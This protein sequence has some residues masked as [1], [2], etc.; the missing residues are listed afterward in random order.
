[1]RPLA[2]DLRYAARSLAKAPLFSAVAIVSL[3]LALA[4]NTSVF[5]LADA[6]VH[7]YNPYPTAERIVTPWFMGGDRKNKLTF[8]E[9]FRIVRDEMHSYDAI[10]SFTDLRATMQAGA[11]VEDHLAVA[12]SSNLFELLGVKPVLGRAFDPGDT[13]AAL[14]SFSLWTRVFNA[15]PLSRGLRFDLGHATFTAVGVMPRGVHFPGNTDIW[16]PENA[17]SRASDERAMGP[18]PVLRLQR[19]KTVQDARTEITGIAARVTAA[20]SPRLPVG[21]RIM[22]LQPP[23]GRPPS[24]FQSF[25]GGT[26]LMVLL[27]ACANLATMMLARGMARR[28]ETA[29]RMALGASRR[30]VVRQVLAECG[31]IVGAGL[32]IGVLLTIWALH[33]IP[34]FAT[35]YVPN[36]GDLQPVP[37]W[38][39]FGFA[40]GATIAT[41]VIAG[42]LPALRAASTDPSEPMKEGAGTTTGRLRDRYNPL[43]IVEVALSTALLM[44]SG[45]FVINVVRLA[46]F[47]FQYAAKRLVTAPLFANPKQTPDTLGVERFYDELVVRA[48]RVPRAVIAATLH[49]E[50]PDGRVI[51][52][53]EG[54]SGDHWINSGGV[55]VVSPDYLRTFRIPIVTGRDFQQGD[56]GASEQG[57]VIV[58]ESAAARL[59]PDMPDPVGRMVKL[60][61]KESKRP[62]LRVVGVAHNVEDGPRV[63]QDLPPEPKV[64][65]VYAHDYT[66]TR[67]L[68][69]QGDGVDGDRGRTALALAVRR[70]IESFAPGMSVPRVEPWLAHYEGTLTATGY[71]ASLFG[72]FGIFGLVLCAVGLYGVLAYS[73]SRRLREFAVRVA[74]GARRRDVARI[75][76]HDAAVTA[77]A[78]VGIGAFFALRVTRMI[79]DAMSGMPYATVIALVGA[80]LVLFGAAALA[81][82]GPIRRAARADPVEI[83]RAI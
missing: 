53:E 29:I 26:V 21:G 66:R 44:C 51:F 15:A 30:V 47:E 14:I 82:L 59:W 23:W 42:A 81:A 20:Y 31:L 50:V 43:I 54:K 7:P 76:I 3:G 56:E 61:F 24:I 40:L 46:A 5:A 28:R 13:Q 72:A 49:G 38:R 80:E 19:G 70:E 34:H 68:I 39:V 55:L 12:A 73:V 17:L 60:G 10:A 32:A 79:A 77:L 83:L 48:R 36:I 64:Y 71:M 65:V 11:V 45:F 41:I 9:R 6:V 35:P 37:S 67:D 52:A 27:I 25:L 1:M 74:L 63:D 69:V 33:V 18:I 22:P 8:A 57:V 78:G 58:D 75:V 4:L 62:W 16:V 2:S